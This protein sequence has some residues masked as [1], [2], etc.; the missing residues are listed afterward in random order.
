MAKKNQQAKKSFISTYRIQLLVIGLLVLLLYSRTVKFEFVGLDDKTLILDNYKFIKD[1]GNIKAAFVNDVFYNPQAPGGSRAYYRPIMTLSLMFDSQLSGQSPKF[2]H[3][4][5]ILFHL[6]CSLLLFR[7]FILLRLSSE[8]SFAGTVLFAVHPVLSQAIGW[9]PGRNDSLLTMFILASLI[10]FIQFLETKNKSKLRFH[11]LFFALALFSKETA[12]FLPVL[13]ILYYR[14]I[15][16][17]QEPSVKNNFLKSNTKSL[18]IGYLLVLL[19]WFL[20][21]K[22]VIA[23]T[24]ADLSFAHLSSSF[25]ENMPIYLQIVQKIIAPYNLSIMSIAK[26]TNFIVS[27]VLIAA[28]I[29]LLILSKQKRWN[30]ILFGFAWFNVFLL[31]AFVV[32][33][34]TGF[35]HRAYLPLIGFLLIVFEVD[36]FKN[37]DYKKIHSFI[38]IAIVAIAFCIINYNHTPAFSNKFSFWEK[39]AANSPHSSL[40]KLNYGAALAEQGKTDEAVKVYRDGLIINY[41]EPMIHNNLGAIYAQRLLYADAEKE[42]KEENRVNPTYS[43]AFYNLGVVYE[44]MGRETEMIASWEKALSINSNHPLA[45][46][47]LDKYYRKKNGT[48]N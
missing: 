24:T 40:A 30:Y 48:L 26:D 7:F 17:S 36:Y 47:A 22:S 27:S 41:S 25:I 28:I 8:T 3:L 2:Y 35:E 18:T 11:I 34:L 1:L 20:L 10:F 14:S 43:D 31:P 42:F 13:C 29:V 33:I 23:T 44:K 45:R 9:I 15:F 38:V 37:L 21:R 46:K 6:I 16:K 4:I 39:A 19:P 12:V 32:P 5:N